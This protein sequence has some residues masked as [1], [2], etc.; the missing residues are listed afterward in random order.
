[1]RFFW[2]Q[3][4][5]IAHW[6]DASYPAHAVKLHLGCNGNRR[7]Y[8]GAAPRRRP[9]TTRRLKRWTTRTPKGE[10]LPANLSFSTLP[11]WPW[12]ASRDLLFIHFVSQYVND[13]TELER[14]SDIQMREP[15]PEKSSGA[16]L[17]LP[18]STLDIPDRSAIPEPIC[19]TKVLQNFHK[20]SE[21]N[22]LIAPTKLIDPW[23][24]EDRRQAKSL[25]RLRRWKEAQDGGLWGKIKDAS[26][27]ERPSDAELMRLVFHH[28]PSP[29][30]FPVRIVDFYD[31][32]TVRHDVPLSTCLEHCREF[33]DVKSAF[34]LYQGKVLMRWD[35][36][37]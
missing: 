8:K 31:G 9:P 37:S 28:F 29:G 27:S 24:E 18:R 14:Q 21:R 6:A 23:A 30:D 12:S 22:V 33:P 4:S 7:T 2:R 17:A 11:A 13:M 19:T 3:R 26:R 1:L 35:S 32:R 10:R 25:R 36:H 16:L 34:A 5:R 20:V 15:H